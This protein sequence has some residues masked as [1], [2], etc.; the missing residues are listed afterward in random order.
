MPPGREQP[1]SRTVLRLVYPGREETPGAPEAREPEASP[2][3]ASRPSVRTETKPPRRSPG[4]APLSISMDEARVAAENRS[5]AAIAPG[6][7]RWVFAARVATALDGG[8]AAV[9]APEKRERLIASA[10]GL[11]LRPFDANLIVAIVQDTARTT[12]AP[13]GPAAAERLEL[14]TPAARPRPQA[15]R[16]AW[17]Y[18]ALASLTLGVALFAILLAWLNR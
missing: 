13:L 7:A 6:D 16:L 2:A 11:G 4:P 5:A 9:L 10:R 8:R 1:E 3:P 14:V 15:D 17:L 12:G 18:P